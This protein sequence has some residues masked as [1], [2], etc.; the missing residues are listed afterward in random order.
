[1]KQSDIIR[2]FHVPKFVIEGETVELHC[3]MNREDWS[4]LHSLIW[5]KVRKVFMD[6]VN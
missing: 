4:D 1:M 3:G 5:F 2:D 6:K